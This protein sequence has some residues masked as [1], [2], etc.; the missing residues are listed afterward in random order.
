[1]RPVNHHRGVSEVHGAADVFE[2]NG[3]VDLDQLG[4]ELNRMASGLEEQHRV[5]EEF[6]R[7]KLELERGLRHAD[8]L[9][10]LGITPS[11]IQNALKEQNA[12]AP[13]GRIGAEPA[14]R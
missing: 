7:Q 14:P 13:A 11:D 9:A 12:Q 4:E 6:Y 3:V 5:R 10:S 1:M 8:K 2:P